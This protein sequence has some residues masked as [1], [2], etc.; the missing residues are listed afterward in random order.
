MGVTTQEAADTSVLG[1]F[2][3][4]MFV[5]EGTLHVHTHLGNIVGLVPDHRS[6]V[7][8]AIK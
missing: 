6:T 7:S 5:R 1:K 2:P 3:E 8:V 4:W